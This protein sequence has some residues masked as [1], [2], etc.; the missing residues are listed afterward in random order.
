MTQETRLD[1]LARGWRGPWLAAL[2]ALI[3]SLPGLIALPPLDR[4]ESLFA[5]ATS[6]ML[7]TG[8]FVSIRYQDHP[9]DKKPVA[10]N[11]LQ[12]ASVSLLSSPQA[13]QIWAYRLPSLLGAMLAAAAL[14][15]GVARFFGAGTGLLAGAILA[16]TLLLSAEAG[17]AKT[18]AVL[19][20]STTLAMTAFA[21]LYA[22][23][24]ETAPGPTRRTQA[25]FW[26]GLAL[27]I[28]DK[29]PVGPMVVVLAGL[30]L[31]AWEREAPW[32]RAL[33]W[34]W[35]L[36]AVAA[37]VGP[38]AMAIT[39]K[40]DGRFWVG[41]IGGDMAS[42][43]AGGDSGHGGPPG[44][45]SLLA[46]LLM[47]PA[48]A[49]L[50][51]GL[52]LGWKARAE[53]GVRFAL[54]WLVPTWLV[55]EL[56]PTKLPHY[57]LPAYGALAWLGAVALTR[58]IGRWSAWIGAA[59]ALLAGVVIAVV[60]GLAKA[61]FGGP[62]ATGWSLAA[63]I[64]SVLAGVAG[65]AMVLAPRPRTG[66]A[67]A[68]ALGIGAHAAL[69]GLAPRL[70]PLWLSRRIVAALD[71][72]RLDPRD[73]LTPGPVTVVGFAEPSL[74]FL[75]GTDTELGDVGDG[76]DAI[77]EGRPAVV[78]QRQDAAFRRELADDNLKASAVGSA[79][80][81]DYSTGRADVLTLYRADAPPKPNA[82]DPG[83]AP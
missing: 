6:Q 83:G 72:A 61:K 49:L 34:G 76:A 56:L 7:E 1:S 65:V 41:S 5:Q 25:L 27:A 21:R 73:G 47:F 2:V 9:R 14:A 42:K 62:A 58:P 80:G 28:L 53:P 45:H 79:S 22:A 57:P 38:W 67:A 31:W 13:R 71:Q 17:I 69:A 30:T 66:M 39:V 81:L 43:M 52:A 11:W 60:A 12:A 82:Q 29:G 48:S 24:R 64:L 50:P 23:A 44:L 18:D 35:G 3:A 37:I 19:C 15:W 78:E 16:S 26:L 40:T 75:L 68:L 20:G 51:A 32:A 36:I 46:I 70:G 59:F 10:I 77:S 4:D 54:A 63:E 33:G 74:V 8:D 55:F